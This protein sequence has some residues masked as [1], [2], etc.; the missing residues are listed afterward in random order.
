M[1]A[2]DIQ[3]F[4]CSLLNSNPDRSPA[5]AAIETCYEIVR[6]SG[7]E[8]LTGLIKEL[9][10]AVQAMVETDHSTT[11]VSSGTE[12]FKRFITLASLDQEPDFEECKK[13]LLDRGRIFLRR[14][15]SAKSTIE[16]VSQPFIRD[17]SVILVHSFS[18]VV[19]QALAGACSKSIKVFVTESGPDLSG[20]IMHERLLDAGI[21]ST[22]IL[23]AAAAYIMDQVHFVVIGADGVVENGGVINKIGSY[24]IA[25][26]AK[27]ANKPLYVM[28]ESFKFVRQYPLN[29]RDVPDSFKYPASLMRS[30]AHLDVCHPLVDYTP[31]DL[32][33]LLFTDLGVM[34]PAQVSDE[35]V[36]L[37]L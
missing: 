14:V 15:G 11:C 23:D 13:V 30:G 26:C 10:D 20:R 2:N 31:P 18:R 5:L 12:L 34:T 6:R 35:L 17:G 36:K 29:Q 37:Y 28:A 25:V 33:S 27:H 7:A 9:Q 16:S 4:F 24:G 19:F 8:T 32:I 22:L 3:D 21:S 1:N